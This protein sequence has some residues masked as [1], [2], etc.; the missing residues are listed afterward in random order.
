[1]KLLTP[2]IILIHSVSLSHKDKLLS[3]SFAADHKLTNTFGA[4]N[5][6]EKN[7]DIME[8]YGC[9]FS[10]QFEII[11]RCKMSPYSRAQQQLD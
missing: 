6:K 10:L 11:R 4:L 5:D 7:D 9:H 3:I 1:M 2:S 8:K